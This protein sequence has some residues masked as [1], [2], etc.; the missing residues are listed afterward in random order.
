MG[1]L[2]LE[3]RLSLLDPVLGLPLFVSQQGFVLS[4]LRR[5]TF[6]RV[7]VVS[8]ICLQFV[9]HHDGDQLIARHQITFLDQQLPDL[10]TD[11]RA[12]D[13][14]LSGN[15]PSENQ[16][17]RHRPHRVVPSPTD[18]QQQHQNENAPHQASP[19]PPV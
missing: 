12:D 14:I 6:D 2:R 10:T 3:A 13:H 17:H 11:L 9:R 1:N 5:D 4:H 16:R 8:A 18:A 19:R 7:L 15:D